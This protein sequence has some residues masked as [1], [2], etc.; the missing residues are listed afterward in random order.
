MRTFENNNE[1]ED[2]TIGYFLI[3]FP[4]HCGNVHKFNCAVHIY[5]DTA[6]LNYDYPVK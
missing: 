5:N 2:I 1:I 4:P 6:D 3:D